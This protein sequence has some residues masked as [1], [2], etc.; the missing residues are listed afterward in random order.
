MFKKIL[1][2]GKKGK[3][4]Q[5]E[6][7]SLKSDGANEKKISAD[8]KRQLVDLLAK[9]KGGGGFRRSHLHISTDNKKPEEKKRSGIWN[10]KKEEESRDQGGML[11]HPRVPNSEFKQQHNPE[12]ETRKVQKRRAI[13]IFSQIG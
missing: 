13:R 11:V 8:S 9:S 5:K 1:S 6:G 10:Q 2:E 7:G 3:G 4:T 12:K